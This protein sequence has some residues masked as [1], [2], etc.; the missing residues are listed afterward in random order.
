ML[1][2]VN[3]IF[4]AHVRELAGF[5]DAPEL[6]AGLETAIAASVDARSATSPAAP[7]DL[8]AKRIAAERVA[9]LKKASRKRS[10]TTRRPG[11]SR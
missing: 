1:F 10:K 5:A 6:A 4:P 8:P 2:I 7:L 11:R 3:V 9:R